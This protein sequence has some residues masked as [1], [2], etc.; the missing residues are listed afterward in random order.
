M[1]TRPAPAP[2]VIHDPAPL[3]PGARFTLPNC[4]TVFYVVSVFDAPG[5]RRTIIGRTRNGRAYTSAAYAAALPV[6]GPS[7]AS[8]PLRRV[9]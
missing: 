8:A 2:P 7:E 5:G 1:A 6:Y 4:A 3:T 9:R